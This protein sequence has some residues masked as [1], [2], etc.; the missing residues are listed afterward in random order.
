MYLIFAVLMGKLGEILRPILVVTIIV[1]T[2]VWSNAHFEAGIRGVADAATV[3][4]ENCLMGFM[5]PNFIWK[6]AHTI[7]YTC[8]QDVNIN[9]LQYTGRPSDYGQPTPHGP[10]QITIVNYEEEVLL[11]ACNI[12]HIV[13]RWTIQTTFGTG[14]CTQRIFVHG[15]GNFGSQHII[16]PKDY[17]LGNCIGSVHPNDLP[18]EFARPRW[19]ANGCTMLGTSYQDH[20]VIVGG[21]GCKKI[22]RTW[23][24]IDWCTYQANV[25]NSPGIWTHVQI[26]K[27]NDLEAPEILFCP[28]DVTVSSGNNCQGTQVNLD[29]LIASDNCTANPIV[30]NNRNAGGADASG[31]YPLGTTRVIFTVRDDCGNSATC[32]VQVTV[33]DLIKPTPIAH[34]GLTGVL[35]DTPNGPRLV[36]N[37]ALFNRGSYDNCTPQG[38]L[39]FEIEPNTFDCENLGRNDIRFIV[40]D[41]SGNSDWVY[42]YI[43]IQEN[44]GMCPDSLGGMV[45]G[46]VMSEGGFL[47]QGLNVGVE[48]GVS[49]NLVTDQFGRYQIRGLRRNEDIEIQPCQKGSLMSGVD[50]RDLVRLRQH[51]TGELPLTSHYRW[52]AADIN[53]SGTVDMMDFHQL[54]LMLLLGLDSLPGLMPWKY[55]DKSLDLNDPEI[56]CNIKDRSGASISNHG[57]HTRRIDFVAVKMGDLDGSYVRELR[58]QSRNAEDFHLMM[59]NITFLAGQLIRVPIFLKS[60]RSLE[61]L[62]LEWPINNTA[63]EVL[64]LESRHKGIQMDWVVT[65]Q[66]KLSIIADGPM[67]QDLIRHEAF[68]ILTLKSKTSGTLFKDAFL[69]DQ[70]NVIATGTDLELNELLGSII[71]NHAVEVENAE[72]NHLSVFPNPTSDFCTLVFQADRDGISTLRLTDLSGKLLDVQNLKVRQGENE[73]RYQLPRDLTSGVYILQVDTQVQTLNKKLIVRR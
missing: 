20:V 7:P 40:Y 17:D 61:G 24:V 6:G 50:I 27:L 32:D 29:K 67:Y 15:V 49:R 35:M 16:W 25:P 68:L 11:N 9:C 48:T 31:F 47:F 65:E 72:V 38:A 36:V 46:L 39:R 41:E 42:T 37:A 19:Q 1:C 30:S 59:P 71:E 8:P 10:Y 63:I 69:L 62:H 28:E 3:K 44:M 5:N 55:I 33:R 51:I 13:R 73:I 53:Q 18:F 22:L 54:R 52:L 56:L 43:I 60:D 14:T 23:R 12:G 4:P 58:L 45:S 57:R 34:H 21:G 2:M 64:Q 70:A 26:I 66:N